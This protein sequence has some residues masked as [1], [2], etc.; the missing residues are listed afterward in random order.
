MIKNLL[1]TAGV[2][3]SL[4]FLA[5]NAQAALVVV[6]FESESNGTKSNGYVTDDSALVQFSAP[7]GQMQIGDFSEG[8]SGKS[9]AVFGGESSRLEMT[10][11]QNVNHLSLAFG[12]DDVCCTTTATVA[13]LQVFSGLALL[14]TVDVLINQN[15]AGDQVIAFA[16]GLFD[17][18]TFGYFDLAGDAIAAEVVDNITFGVASVSAVPVPAALPLLASGLAGLVLIGRRKRKA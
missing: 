18:A 12:N 4:V 16:G 7:N 9:L 8:A 11:S 3:L 13:R 14:D 15:D 6:D 17:R 1:K 10:F 2:A 5:G